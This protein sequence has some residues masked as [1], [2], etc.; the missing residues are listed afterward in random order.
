V[1]HNTTPCGTATHCSTDRLV[2][3]HATRHNH[4]TQHLLLLLLLL[5][6]LLLCG[7]GGAGG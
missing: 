2:R 3:S 6:L 1:H 5:W 4:T 7:G